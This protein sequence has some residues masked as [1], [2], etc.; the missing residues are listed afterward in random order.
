M[1]LTFPLGALALILIAA[2]TALAPAFAQDEVAAP[3]TISPQQPEQLQRRIMEAYA[4]GQKKIVV[5]PGLYSIPASDGNANLEFKNLENF[6]IDATGAIFSMQDNSKTG[7]YFWNCRNVIFRGATVRNATIPFTQGSI[8][9]IAP[10]RK[11]LELQIDDGYPNALDDAARF[12][13]RSAYYIFDRD[14]RRLK[15]QTY[16]NYNSGIERLGERRFRLTFD[17]ALSDQIE[18]GDGCAT[19]GRGNTGVH[20]DNCAQMQIE[21]VDAEFAGAFGWFESEGAGGNRYTRIAVQPGPRPIG[22]T[23]DP[24]L[25]ENADAFHSVGVRVGPTI[26]DSKFT[27][28]PDDGIAINGEYQMVREAQ[29]NVLVCMRHRPGAPYEAGDR[30]AWVG[31]NGVPGGEARVVST[32][33]LADGFLPPIETNLDHFRDNKFFFEVTLDAPLEAHE[34]DLISNLERTGN[35]YVLRGN[36]ISDHRARGMMLKASDGLVEN[37]VIDGSSIAALVM[38]PEFWWGDGNYATNVTIRGNTFAHCGYATTGPWNEQAGVLTLHGAG[39]SPDARGHSGITIEGNSFI[40]NDGINVLLDGVENASLMGNKFVGAQQ[41]ENRRG[42]DKG[43]DIGALVWIG[44][45]KNVA[46]EGNTVQRLGAANTERVVLSQNASEIVT[47]GGGL[48]V[49]A[50]E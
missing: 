50:P 45:A 24:L 20:L 47:T 15:N 28:M 2:N 34:G 27:R 18:V 7:V 25:S 44:R 9:A 17:A 1:K 49:V 43:Y 42:A 16:D 19:R 11:S 21:D 38:A 31:K 40:G 36:S 5:A 37:N 8:A 32:K 4:A 22:A 46:I 39:D 35:G 10:D 48:Y 26:E 12:N 33:V 41:T 3:I 14:T 6:E 13:A 30:V 23:Q 29:G